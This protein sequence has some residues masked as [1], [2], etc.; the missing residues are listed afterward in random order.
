MVPQLIKSTLCTMHMHMQVSE[1]R[2]LHNSRNHEE[3]YSRIRQEMQKLNFRQKLST[4]DLD[5]L[6]LCIENEIKKCVYAQKSI[7]RPVISIT[8]L[9]GNE[10]EEKA[11]SSMA[12]HMTILCSVDYQDVLKHSFRKL[13]SLGACLMWVEENLAKVMLRYALI[14]DW[15]LALEVL[16]RYYVM[17]KQKI[18]DY[19]FYNDVDEEDFVQAFDMA[20]RYEKRFAKLVDDSKCSLC[21][22]RHQDSSDENCTQDLASAINHSCS[23]MRMISSQFIPNIAIYLKVS[24]DRLVGGE[25][26]QGNA[27]V[28]VISAVLDFFHGLERILKKIEYLDD[29]SAYKCL[30]RYFDKYIAI[31]ISK[32]RLGNTI[33]KSIVVLNT[34]LFAR[35]TMSDFMAR[36]LGQAGILE[37]T[38]NASEQIRK[39]EA[40]H[41]SVIDSQ[42]SVCFEKISFESPNDLAKDIIRFIDAEIISDATKGIGEETRMV[43]LESM[44]S[45]ML[46]RIYSIGITS[47][48]AEAL[49][50]EVAEV[51]KHLKPKVSVIPM[52]DVLEKYLKIFLCSYD[53]EDCFVNNFMLMSEDIFSFEQIISSVQ[54]KE[55][56][57]NLWAAYQRHTGTSTPGIASLHF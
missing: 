8:L 44:V 17:T 24:F 48:A 50:L 7:P 20:L 39:M 54:C 33:Y 52:M 14:S 2:E 42:L 57:G 51:K 27:K 3:I 38:P 9:L 40:F 10:F 22:C 55:K 28:C 16:L 41:G 46:S 49:L 11:R 35:E 4:D 23:H 13:S 6:K 34:L 37:D 30:V 29:V 15:N 36:V 53:D 32:I 5:G 19:F 56:K 25:F 12:S 1:L 21:M 26:E 18:C 45:Q 31:L 47:D 43:L